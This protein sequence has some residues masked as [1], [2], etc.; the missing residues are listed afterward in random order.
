M[1]LCMIS[2]IRSS[3]EVFVFPAILLNKDVNITSD[4]FAMIIDRSI[5]KIAVYKGLANMYS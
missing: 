4:N 5:Q 3:I 2:I 1:G